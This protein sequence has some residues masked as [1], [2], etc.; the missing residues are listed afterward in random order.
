MLGSLGRGLVDL[1]FRLLWEAAKL[2]VADGDGA[3]VVRSMRAIGVES[4]LYCE[5]LICFRLSANKS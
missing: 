4:P 5:R 3:A 2:V 1:V